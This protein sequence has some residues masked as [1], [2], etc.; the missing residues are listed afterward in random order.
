MKQQHPTLAL[1]ETVVQDLVSR[2]R[3]A[4]LRPGDA[5]YAQA[6]RVYNAMINKQPALI[7]RCVDVADV[8]V[9]VNFARE[10]Q[11][12]LAVQGW[13]TQRPRPGYL[14]RRPGDRPL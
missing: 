8:I 13:R 1:E 7:A 12:P 2:L 4:L 10:H 14:R 5:D 6:A 9:A 3:E 11:L